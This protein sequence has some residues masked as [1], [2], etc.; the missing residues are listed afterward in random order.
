MKKTIFA[1]FSL[2]AFPVSLLSAVDSALVAAAEKYLNSITG[3]SGDFVQM[4]GNK[5]DSGEFTMLRPGRVRLDYKTTPVQLIGDGKD[6]YFYDKKLDQITTV[7]MT[8]TPAGILVRK[9]INLQTADIVV[10]ETK[11]DKDSFS[12]KMALKGNEGVG[13]MNVAFSHSPVKLQSWIV[14]DALGNKTAVNFSD[15]KTKTDFGKNWF[16]I[17]RH[18][19]IS[20]SGDDSFY[21]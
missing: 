16:Q 4:A 12:L 8:S 1:L 5:K 10:L 20:N 2:F 6:L 7:P 11:S 21:E 9:N 19:T 15:L 18:K 3:L 13:S 17:G 14:T